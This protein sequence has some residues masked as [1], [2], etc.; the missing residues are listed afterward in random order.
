MKKLFI[1]LIICNLAGGVGSIFTS[2]AISEW[3]QYLNKPSFNPPN[4]IFGPVW[5]LL[6]SLM[7]IAL[8]LIWKR[9]LENKDVNYAVR[10]FLIHLIFNALW[11]LLFFGLRNPLLGLIEIVVLWAMIV[12]SI[13]MFY[14]INKL[15]GVLLVPYLLWVSFATVLNYYLWQL[16]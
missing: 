9:G 6:Y 7:G 2:N 1:S 8:Y 16:N 4:W 10:F 3:Y 14:R 11:S 12:A 15:A 13:V 5:T